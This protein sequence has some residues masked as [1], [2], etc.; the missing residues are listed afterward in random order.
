MFKEKSDGS[1]RSLIQ[2]SKSLSKQ[3]IEHMVFSPCV[4]KFDSSHLSVFEVTSIP[5]FFYPEYKVGFFSKKVR[6]ALEQFKPNIIHVS[7]PDLTGHGAAKYAKKHDIPLLASFH[8]HFPSYL[9]YYKLGFLQNWLWKKLR[10]H[11]NQCHAVF[12][13]TKIIQDELLSHGI[14]GL[15]KSKENHA[16]KIWSRGIDEEQFSPDKRN[17]TLRQS[18]GG[19][20]KFYVLYVG[21]M[22]WYKNLEC[23]RKVYDDLSL[24]KPELFKKIKF[25]FVGDGP[26][27]EALKNQMPK[28]HFFGSIK[29]EKIGQYY[30]SADVLFF[31][32]TTETF[33]QVVQ[34]ALASGCPAMVS[35]QGG[36]QEIVKASQAG[37]IFSQDDIQAYS[38]SIQ[39]L[40]V[41]LNKRQNLKEKAL[42]YAKTKQWD[43]VNQVVIDVY[44][45]LLNLTVP[46]Q[47]NRKLG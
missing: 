33:G 25:C 18:W 44:K 21:R 40:V 34:E 38:A 41:N 6:L 32:S 47:K 29:P 8:T 23:I 45:D 42:A 22:V 31:P 5:I 2:L 27:K 28:A 14:T 11:Y 30:A 20:D 36:C 39:E 1:A 10:Q 26:A 3:G 43:Q 16:L 37:Y 9:P 24:H 19:D 4:D 12:T 46:L 13:P 15:D 35:N 7:T 17:V